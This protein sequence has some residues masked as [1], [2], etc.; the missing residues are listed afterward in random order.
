MQI[1]TYL[2]TTAVNFDFLCL[3]TTATVVTI[4]C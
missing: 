3:G 4:L 2:P 1:T